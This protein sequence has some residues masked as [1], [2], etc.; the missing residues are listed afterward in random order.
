MNEEKL[1]RII[2][3]LEKIEKSGRKA[4]AWQVFIRWVFQH[5]FVLGFLA[6]ISYA[7]WEMWAVLSSISEL[8][9][10]IL[11]SLEGFKGEITEKVKDLK[12]W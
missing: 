4:P 5:F 3:L 12:F 6:A 11:F 10:G 7:I 8:V 1:D 2:E 9:N